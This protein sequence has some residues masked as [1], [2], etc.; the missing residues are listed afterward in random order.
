M[1]LDYIIGE[2]IRELQP[3]HVTI[4]SDHGFSEYSHDLHGYYLDNTG[5]GLDNIFAFTPYME[6][7]YGLKDTEYGPTDERNDITESEVEDIKNQ[8]GDLGYF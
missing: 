5:Y 4:L 7:I 6:N 2:L 1:L 3:T 8:L